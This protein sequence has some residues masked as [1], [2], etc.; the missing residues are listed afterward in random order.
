[1]TAKPSR[2]LCRAT[3]RA[4]RGREPAGRAAAV[5][6]AAC[7]RDALRGLRET[8]PAGAAQVEAW[9]YTNLNRAAQHRFAPGRRRRPRRST[10]CRSAARCRSTAHRLV[11]RQRTLR[12]RTCRASPRCRP[13]SRSWAWRRR[14]HASRTCSK[15]GS[16]ASPPPTG[17]PL[18]ALNTALMADG[19]C[20]RVAQGRRSSKTPIARRLDRRAAATRRS[21]SIRAI[22][23]VGEAGSRRRSSKA[24]SGAATAPISANGVTEIALERRRRAA[25]LQAAGR[26]RR[27]LPSGD[28]RRRASP[29]ARSYDSFV[30]QLGGRLAR[31]EIRVA[32][33]GRGR[34][35]PAER[36][37]SRC[38]ASSMSTTRP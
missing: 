38:A 9:K 17:M 15:A 4:G 16:A 33:D 7:A 3:T 1:M 23:V 11:L 35:L 20:I 8:R 24:T 26:E 37:L 31:N 5:A 22:L 12:G 34:R 32:L 36:R 30:L 18:V 27:R 19:L 13:A 10:A 21:P 14:W 28:D 29:R 25:P 6:R 2:S